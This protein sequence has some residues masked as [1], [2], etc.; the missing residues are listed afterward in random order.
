MVP[1][2]Q[3]T[4]E[5]AR[6]YRAIRRDT[7]PVT[8]KL[9]GLAPNEVL[10]KAGKELGMLSGNVLVFDSEDESL[11]LADR[12]AHDARWQGTNAVGHLLESAELPDREREILQAMSQAYLSLFRV[13][14]TFPDQGGVVLEDMLHAGQY[15]VMDINMARSAP[16][17][18]AVA[19]RLIPFGD[20]WVGSGVFLPFPLGEAEEI[21]KA[22]RLVGSAR[23]RRVPAS[24]KI[25]ARNDMAYYYRRYRRSKVISIGYAEIESS[26]HG[27]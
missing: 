21:V 6:R 16:V 15:L 18:M 12:L 13:R 26:D 24:R 8:R 10:L 9:Y 7:Q 5:M 20:F 23:L 22:I 3:P 17:G 11:F 25:M 19:L 27:G 14:Q 4:P 2:M 1:T